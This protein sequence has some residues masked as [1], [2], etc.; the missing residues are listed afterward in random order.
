ME[1]NCDLGETR[2]MCDSFFYSGNFL[3]RRNEGSCLDKS[4]EETSVLCNSL[5]IYVTD[6]SKNTYVFHLVMTLQV[7]TILVTLRNATLI[8][9]SFGRGGLGDGRKILILN[10]ALLY[11]LNLSIR[12]FQ[13]VNF[14]LTNHD[15]A[16]RKNLA[17]FLR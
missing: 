16:S 12:Q 2:A 15:I 9:F 11:I 17:R 3:K 13:H 4:Y 8:F 14:V 10:Q 5:L 7:E 6:I 1:G